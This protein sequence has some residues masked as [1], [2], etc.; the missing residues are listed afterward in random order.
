M[1]VGLT[2]VVY[3]HQGSRAPAF[4][5]SCAWRWRWRI[6]VAFI[7]I[8]LRGQRTRAQPLIDLTLFRQPEFA[9]GLQPRAAARPEQSA[10]NWRWAS[11]CNWCCIAHLL[12]RHWSW[13]PCRWAHSLPGRWPDG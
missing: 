5:R 8:Y 13:C 7:A 3:R 12:R 11:T 10:W 4:L 1:L 6:G 9:P 2:A